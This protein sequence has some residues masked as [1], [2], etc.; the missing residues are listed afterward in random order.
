MPGPEFKPEEIGH[1]PLKPSE[2]S[3]VS[4]GEDRIKAEIQMG[5]AIANL[6]GIYGEIDE[7]VITEMPTV[8]KRAFLMERGIR[9]L[10]KSEKKRK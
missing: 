3:R 9:N 7:E 1:E 10:S 6:T 5:K 2:G 4:L 8:M